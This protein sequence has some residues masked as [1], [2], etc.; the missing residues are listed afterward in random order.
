[1]KDRIVVN[2]D[3]REYGGT[4]NKKTKI[5]FV[6]YSLYVLGSAVFGLIYLFTP[7][8]MPYHEVA[9]GMPW[10]DV[11]PPLQ[12]L[13]LA[14]IKGVGTGLICYSL[15]LGILLFIPFRRGENWAR[16]TI[17]LIGLL[18]S[19]LTLYVMSTVMLSTPASPPWFMIVIGIV[20]LILGFAF[21][22]DMAKAKDKQSPEMTL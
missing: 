11:A 18:G 3:S 7:Q 13:L 14:L 6:F 9:V 22:K 4:M 16:W 15:L 21:S 20:E 5:G 12:I 2:S 1:M 19:L 8:F 10:S 17:L